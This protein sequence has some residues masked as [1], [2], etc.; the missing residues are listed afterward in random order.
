MT[1]TSRY[2][3]L[4]D[5]KA[6]SHTSDRNVTSASHED[7]CSIFKQKKMEIIGR[8]GKIVLQLYGFD[9]MEKKKK[10]TIFF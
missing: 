1:C 4:D 7:V 9:T 2:S 10:D 8:V 6:T 5:N 3:I